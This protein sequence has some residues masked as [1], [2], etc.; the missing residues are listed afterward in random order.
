MLYILCYVFIVEYICMFLYLSNKRTLYIFSPFL[1]LYTAYLLNDIIPML[2]LPVELP[3]NLIRVE[4]IT[5]FINIIT[6]LIYLKLYTRSI[7][8]NNIIYNKISLKR[9]VILYA[10]LFL[11]LISGLLSGVLPAIIR[12]SNVE[13]LRRTGEVGLGII[14][15]IPTLSL[16][17]IAIILLLQLNWSK[18][19]KKICAYCF[20][21]GVFL[22]LITGN[23]SGIL[24]GVTLLIIYFNIKKRGLKWYEC[25][26]FNCMTPIA[27]GFL[28][29]LRGGDIGLLGQKILSFF[30]YPV[31][32]YIANTIPVAREISPSFDFNFEEYTSAITKFI[33]RFLWP[34]KPLSFD[35]KLKEMVGYDFEGGGIYTTLP[36]DIYINTGDTFFIYYI[37][38]LILIHFLYKKALD[39]HTSDYT[40]IFLIFLLL[41][42]SITA[43]IFYIE[44]FTIYAILLILFYQRRKTL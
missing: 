12:G 16:K 1:Q 30:V 24:T 43:Q 20:F 5:C 27:A 32:L 37:L 40:K 15:D 14:R 9:N 10:S 6:L 25:V 33:P 3:E 34:D 26:A 29:A 21:I 42:G 36:V 31:T 13:D 44:V 4:T 11:L 2:I 23:K 7:S 39:E 18:H 41:N 35:Y 28:Q 17:I 19:W 38:Y 8:Y 22:F